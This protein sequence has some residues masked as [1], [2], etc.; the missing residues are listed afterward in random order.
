[1]QSP[2]PDV[3]F[4]LEHDVLVRCE[5]QQKKGRQPEAAAVQQVRLLQTPGQYEILEDRIILVIFVFNRGGRVLLGNRFRQDVKIVLPIKPLVKGRVIL[6]FSVQLEK[7]LGRARAGPG[8]PHDRGGGGHD[9]FAHGERGP[10]VVPSARPCG[11]ARS[12]A[13]VRFAPCIRWSAARALLAIN[14]TLWVS[15]RWVAGR[16]VVSGRLGI[17]WELA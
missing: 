4:R 11:R 7:F 13:R 8:W 1:M 10:I 17:V 9:L 3:D 2:A 14:F 12:A 15:G 5:E 16:W 6:Y